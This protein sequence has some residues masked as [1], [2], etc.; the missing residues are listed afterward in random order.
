MTEVT[1]WYNNKNI[2]V[3]GATGFVGRCLVEKLLRVCPGI[4]AIY[5]IVRDKRGVRFEDRISV[6]LKH[7]VF[8]KM[9][10]ENPLALN[11]IQFVKGDI[12][13]VNL[14][15]S[16]ADITE[17]TENVS[18]VFHSAADVHFNRRLVDAYNNNVRGTKHT[19]DL[20]TR[21]KHLVV[22]FG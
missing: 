8:S 9:A 4:R 20:A 10:A 6:Y 7:V 21:I 22:T 14:G 19:L 11:K 5:I 15:M 2:F 16:D 1:N 17:I 12:H 3:T 13:E 18:I